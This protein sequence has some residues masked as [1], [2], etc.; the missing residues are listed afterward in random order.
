MSYDIWL[1]AD[2]GGPEPIAVGESWSYTSNCGK[3][4]RAA[5][6]DLA[7]FDGKTAGEC[8]PVLRAGIDEMK[9]NPQ[10]YRALNPGNKWGSYDSL[11]PA[12]EQLAE[13]FAS[14]PLA[15][16]QVWR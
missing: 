13:T 14:S 15:T 12:L 2:L 4:W 9:A 3:M 10:K 11:V 1:T 7:E 6:A 16:V 5:G 8:L